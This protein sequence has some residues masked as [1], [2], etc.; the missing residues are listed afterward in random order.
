MSGAIDIK[1]DRGRLDLLAFSIDQVQKKW[2]WFLALGTVLIVLGIVALSLPAMVTLGI[3]LLLGWLLVIGGVAQAVHA[4][5]ARKSAAFF[6]TLLSAVLY[7]GV[8]VLLLA[9]PLQGI[10]TLT[11]VLGTFFMIE[12]IFKIMLALRLR[13]TPNWYWLLISGIVA[14]LLG[15]IIWAWWPGD[16][17]W[18]IG[19]L[20][21]IDMI[22]SGWSMV[23]IALSASCVRCQRS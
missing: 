5:A 15:A 10:L 22:F 23:M 19:L 7:L 21:G 16:A 6:L 18:V 9:Y 17:P 3:E 20:V 4:L 8:G 1:S 12:G 13:S 11:L 14:L 2:G